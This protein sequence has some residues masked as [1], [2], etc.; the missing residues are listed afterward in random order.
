MRCR[1]RA[2]RTSTHVCGRATYAGQLPQWPPCSSYLVRGLLGLPN[3]AG[4][5]PT[6][7]CPY[8][9]NAFARTGFIRL[10]VGCSNSTNIP[11][12]GVAAAMNLREAWLSAMSFVDSHEYMIVKVR[13]TTL[14]LAG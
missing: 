9:T 12:A 8:Y 3:T 7:S 10:G 5:S 2:A 4:L 1:M 13:F 6:L 11:Y 14:K